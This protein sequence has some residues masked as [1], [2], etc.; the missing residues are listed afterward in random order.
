MNFNRSRFCCAIVL[1]ICFGCGQTPGPVQIKKLATLNLVSYVVNMPA[2]QLRDTLLALFDYKYQMDD[3]GLK[4]VFVDAIADS[5]KYK[6]QV[7][8]STETFNQAVFSKEYFAGPGTR[9]DVYITAMGGYWNSPMY[10]TEGKPLLYTSDF[11]FK[12]KEISKDSTLLMVKAVNPEVV[13]G[14][15]CCSPHGNYSITQKVK[16]TSVEEYILIAFVA[17]KLNIKDIP[18]LKMPR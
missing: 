1:L 17:Q 15:K 16:P 9:N 3:P 12:F 10:F 11:A 7:S 2:K 14:S 8:F 18:A 6:M 13:N 5:S 4:Q